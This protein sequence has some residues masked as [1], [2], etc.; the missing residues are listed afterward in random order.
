MFFFFFLFFPFSVGCLLV[1]VLTLTTAGSLFWEEFTLWSSPLRPFLCLFSV[2]L[3][4]VSVGVYTFQWCRFSSHS[5]VGCI[6]LLGCVW[7]LHSTP[8]LS[9][10]FCHC[11]DWFERTLLF[12]WDIKRYEAPTPLRCLPSCKNLPTRGCLVLWCSKFIEQCHRSRDRGTPSK[13]GGGQITVHACYRMI[14]FFLSCICKT[15]F[16]CL[17]GLNTFIFF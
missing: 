5:R 7:I 10:C 11:F 17:L 3:L 6:F 1:F 16:H 14:F 2:H 15:V 9:C 12:R 13:A 8:Q 4:P